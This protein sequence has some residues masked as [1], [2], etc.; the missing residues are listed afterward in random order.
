VLLIGTKKVPLQHQSK[1]P[2]NIFTVRNKM[3]KKI[4]ILP[5]G[6]VI[7]HVVEVATLELFHGEFFIFSNR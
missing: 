2:K 4:W 1:F 3:Q 7:F 5:G 6:D